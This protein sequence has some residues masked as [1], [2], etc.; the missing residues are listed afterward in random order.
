[1]STA[2]SRT[3]PAVPGAAAIIVLFIAVIAFPGVGLALGFGRNALSE[4]EMRELAPWPAWSWS[5]EGLKGWPGGFERYFE[6]HFALRAQLIGWRSTALWTWLR[7]SASDT[8]L[9]GRD[10]WLFYADDG[11]VSDWTQVEPFS[12]RELADWRETLVGRRAFLAKRG[13]P[14]LFVVAPDKQ[15]VYPEHMPGS[16]RRLRDDY[17]VDQ[18]IAYMRTTTPDFE[19]LDLRGPLLTAKSSEL[20]YDRY[21]THWNDR[22]ALVAYQAIAHALK[23]WFPLLTPLERRDFDTDASVPSGDSTTMLGL[24]DE[25]KRSMPGLVLR[26]GAGY[27]VIAPA[28]PDPYGEDGLLIVEHRDRTLPTAMVF[29][30]SFG[31]RLIPYLSE[32]F[33]RVAYYWQN[34]LDYEDIERQRPDIVIQEFVARHFFTYGPY[35]PMIPE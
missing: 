8:V 24:I 25:G 4:S 34:E 22:G 23:Q 28:N 10:G 2:R 26:R 1:M 21:D 16:L 5:L 13:I 17:R 7:A 14:F 15:M 12:E 31:A 32:H 20:L 3:P 19:I 9:A 6:D 35:P 30:D 33:R 29:R 11:G 27:R 18:L